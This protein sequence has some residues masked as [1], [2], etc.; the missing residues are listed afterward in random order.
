MV[1]MDQTAA[2]S[3]LDA[4]EEREL[5]RRSAAGDAHAF[6]PLVAAYSGK[7]YYY[8]LQ[9]LRNH[10]DAVDAA[11]DAF[12]K[13]YRALPRFDLN[14]PFLP[15]YLRI[16]RNRCLDMIDRRRRQPEQP[17]TEDPADALRV[18]P[19]KVHGPDRRAVGHEEAAR[20]RQVMARLSPDHGEIL[21]LRYFE[22]MTY[23]ELAD[24]LE[25][26]KGTVMSRLYHARRKLAELMRAET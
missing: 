8:A 16:L 4:G 18:I 13:A 17:G 6:N 12:V 14:R 24:V 11:Q 25:I 26:P 19:S 21:H 20:I 1:G 22:D 7:G 3:A 2:P 10:H 5:L 15:W 23:E 9:I